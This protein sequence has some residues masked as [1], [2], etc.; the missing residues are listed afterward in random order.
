MMKASSIIHKNEKRIKVEFPNSKESTQLIKEITGAKWSATMKSWHIPYTK[1]AFAELKQRCPDIEII[2]AIKP[3]QQN[4]D[5]QNTN[6]DPEV[7][8]ANKH[9]NVSIIVSGRKIVVKLPK[10]ETDT[11]FML[12]FRFSRWDKKNY[13]WVIPN[14]DKNLELIK[15]YFKERIL[16]IEINEEISIVNTSENREIKKDEFLVVRANNGRLK[17]YFSY[18]KDVFKKLRS[19]PYSSWNSKLKYQSIPFQESYLKELEE[20]AKGKNLKFLYEIEKA[21]TITKYKSDRSSKDYKKCPEE[22]ISK[23]KEL[24][25]SE[26]TLRVYSSAF[27]QFCNYYKD[28]SLENISQEQITK[29]MQHLVVDRKVSSS[30]HNQAINA[31]KFYYE[32]VLNGDRK[33]YLLDRP[34]KEQKLPEVLNQE[35][36]K[37]LLKCIINIKHRALVMLAYSSGMR[38]SEIVGLK[39]KD[40]DSVQMQIRVQQGKGKKDRITILSERV[41]EILRSYFQQYKPKE[42]LFEGADGGQYSKRSAQQI[43]KDAA[44]KAGIQKKISFHTLRHSFG[45]HLIESGTNLRYIQS[46]LGHE[47]SKT[48][49]IYTHITLKGFDQLRSP[50]DDLGEF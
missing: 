2:P 38:L 27:E 49:E 31:I 22:Y 13:Y 24:H 1:E 16:S 42:W 44:R 46:L 28:L 19:Y 11:R 10:S 36:I 30:Y 12:S 40:L 15:D 6:N 7:D 3:A 48:T 25:N 50:M 33:I 45:T 5:P 18:D 35:E 26:N 47:S 23:L 17:I 14:Y 37:Q 34:R 8:H 43:V 39:I 9:R 32:R 29:Y 21:S 4:L 20:F 41:L